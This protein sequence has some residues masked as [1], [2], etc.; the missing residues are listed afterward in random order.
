VAVLY[1]L[2]GGVS[3][4][5][6]GYFFL[7]RGLERLPAKEGF[8]VPSRLL[9]MVGGSLLRWRP[10][11]RM[12]R[13]LYPAGLTPGLFPRLAGMDVW[14]GLSVVAALAGFG[15]GI[16]LGWWTAVAC[17]LA[18]GAIP[19]FHLNL[20]AG[21]YRREVVRDLP[22]ALD[23]LVLAVRA[24]VD[25][26]PASERVVRTLSGSPLGGEWGEALRMMRLGVSRGEALARMGERV[27]V[28]PLRALAEAV[29]QSEALG[30]GLSRIL[31]VQAEQLRRGRLEWAEAAA[32][33]APVKMLFPLVFCVLPNVFVVLLGPVL[34]RLVRA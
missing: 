9:G 20:R 4:L 18:C 1:V 31:S 11:D 32:H 13:G 5:G 25:F 27:G 2:C 24:G 8:G 16:G 26:E 14:A 6:I 12:L 29:K 33:K 3:C 10:L 28:D 21:R 22:F 23:L 30:T 34:F 17:A 15:A 19:F 7:L